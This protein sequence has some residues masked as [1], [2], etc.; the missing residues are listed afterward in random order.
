MT[1]LDAGKLILEIIILVNV[2]REF[3]R[4]KIFHLV[5]GLEADLEWVLFVCF[6]LTMLVFL[7]PFSKTNGGDPVGDLVT[8]SSE[9]FSIKFCGWRDVVAKFVREEVE[10]RSLAINTRHCDKVYRWRSVSK[11]FQSK[12]WSKMTD[13]RW[14][15]SN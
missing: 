7:T 3:T 11:E 1:L 14:L 2:I 8:C 12:S 15:A 6:V 10:V 5:S 4:E 13:I 9:S